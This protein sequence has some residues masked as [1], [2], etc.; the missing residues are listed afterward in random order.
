MWQLPNS[1][2]EIGSHQ[3]TLLETQ[4]IGSRDLTSFQK[5]RKTLAIFERLG[6]RSTIIYRT[7]QQQQKKKTLENNEVILLKFGRKIITNL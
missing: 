7:S 1:V 5:K 4:N 2:D 6:I 3:N